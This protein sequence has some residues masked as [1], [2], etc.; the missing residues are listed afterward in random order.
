MTY[1][2]LLP[3][4]FMDLENVISFQLHFVF[5]FIR[6]HVNFFCGVSYKKVKQNRSVTL[7]IQTY[8]TTPNLF[9]IGLK[10]FIDVAR[11]IKRKKKHPFCTHLTRPE[12]LLYLREQLK[13]IFFYFRGSSFLH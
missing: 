2:R 3:A 13:I 11:E 6:I 7:C 8:C 9:K 12:V 4:N 1:P 10:L 5:A